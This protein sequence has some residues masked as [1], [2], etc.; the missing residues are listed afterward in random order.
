MGGKYTGFDIATQNNIYTKALWAGTNA[1]L[2]QLHT[3]LME[4]VDYTLRELLTVEDGRPPF[5][6]FQQD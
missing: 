2:A 1:K 5:F 6:L 4:E 3:P